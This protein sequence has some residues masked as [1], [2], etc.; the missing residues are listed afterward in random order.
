MLKK[1]DPM[2]V[3]RHNLLQKLIQMNLLSHTGM[4]LVECM[5][6]KTEIEIEELATKL[7]EFITTSD[8]EEEMI[9]RASRLI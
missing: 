1:E 9:E 3:Q 4:K 7:L 5:D 2:A 6:G 8:S